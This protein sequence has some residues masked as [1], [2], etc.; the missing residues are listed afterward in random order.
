[1]D[2]GCHIAMQ[3]QECNNETKVIFRCGASRLCM[4]QDN[5]WETYGLAHLISISS[6]QI[7]LN[8][9]FDFIFFEIHW[10]TNE[11]AKL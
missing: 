11:L 9:W 5:P 4:M 3:G 7:S 8:A 10:Y 6:H 2:I 1:M